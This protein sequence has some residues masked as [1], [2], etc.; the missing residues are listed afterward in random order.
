[1]GRLGADEVSDRA[2]DRVGGVADDVGRVVAERSHRTQH[3]QKDQGDDQAVFD[4]R[5]AAA[6]AQQG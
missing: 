4:R 2:V 1:M 6:V 5:R 3:H